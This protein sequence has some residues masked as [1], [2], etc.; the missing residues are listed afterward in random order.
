MTKSPKKSGS[1]MSSGATAALAGYDYQLDVSILAALHLL[2]ISKAATRITLEPTNEEDLEA[3]LDPSTPGRVQ[4]SAATSGGYRLIVQVK[5]KNDGPWTIDTLK[6]L[7][8]K[9]TNRTPARVHLDDDANRFLLITSADVS[10]PAARKLL[11]TG[12]EDWPSKAD[13]PPG[14][15]TTLR[16][17]PEGRLGIWAGLSATLLKHELTDALGAILRVPRARQKEC[18]EQLRRDARQR[19]R[20]QQPGV[21]TR[22]D[23]VGTIRLFGGYLASAPERDTFVKPG[24]YDDIAQVLDRRNAVVITGPSGTGKTWTA[25]A[26]C[27]RARERQGD[28][29]IINVN[30]T[31]EPSSMRALVDTGPMLHYVEDPWGQYSLRGGS[32]AWTTQLPRLLREARPDRQY[33]ITSRSDMIAQALADDEL[34]RWSVSLAADNYQNGELADIYDRRLNATATDLQAAALAFRTRALDKLETPLELDLFF[35]HLADGPEQGE[36]EYAFYDRI[37]ALAHRDAVEDVVVKYLVDSDRGGQAAILWAIL[38]SRGQIDR[39]QLASLQREMRTQGSPLANDLER[40][41]NRLV[42]TRHLRQPGRTIS[43]SHPSVRAGFATFIARDWSRTMEAFD[44]LLAALVNMPEPQRVWGLETATRILPRI[45]ELGGGMEDALAYAVPGEMQ[46]LIDAW[47]DESLVDPAADFRAVLTLACDVGS[48]ASTPSEVARWFLK[49]VRRGWEFFLDNWEPPTFDDDWYGRARADPR[50]R[51]IA[52]R[53]IREQL[54][55]GSAAYGSAFASRLDRIADNLTPAYLAAAL[56]MVSGGPGMNI[57]AVAG[58]AVRDLTGFEAVVDAA[59]AELRAR[60]ADY[61][62]SGRETWRAIVDGEYDQAYEEGY[63]DHHADDGYVA[64]HFLDDYVRE[65]RRLGNWA[66]LAS[67]PRSAELARFWAD[68]IWKSN[69]PPPLNELQSLLAVCRGAGE[70]ARAWTAINDHWDPALAPELQRMLVADPADGAL[71]DALVRCALMASPDTAE[72]AARQ[73]AQDP[74]SII[75]LLV[76]ARADR[77]FKSSDTRP[78]IRRLVPRLA[79]LPA[80][81]RQVLRALARGEGLD[82]RRHLAS[83]DLLETAAMTAAPAVLDA[84]V[85]VL[86]AT[87]RPVSGAVSRWL[88]ETRDSGLAESAAQAAVRLGDGPLVEQ[89]RLHPRASARTVALKHLVS[90]LPDPL[91]GPVLAMATDRSSAVRMTLVKGLAERP[92]PEHIGALLTLLGDTWANNVPHHDEDISYGVAKLAVVALNRYD[93]LP[94]AVGTAL[95]DR[96]VAT[97]DRDLSNAAMTCA[98]ERCSPAIRERMWC[99]VL[100]N[101][102]NWYRLDAAKALVWADQANPVI[103]TSISAEL[104]RRLAPVLAAAAAALLGRHGDVDQA[105]EVF[106][107]VARFQRRRALVVLGAWALADRDHATAGQLMGLLG[108]PHPA[109]RL[110]DLAEGEKLPANALD[111][112]GHIRVRNAVRD[113]L[114]ENIEPR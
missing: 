41:T 17:S 39:A 48:A 20:S 72:A 92:R 56:S 71:Y 104:L 8:Q 29:E 108:D 85:P 90:F 62:K 7:L 60:D 22:E 63:A 24:N 102:K 81:S 88:A 28:V 105:A 2:L 91:P 43:F 50:S 75:R 35:S 26:L 40:V 114:S 4:P 37:I 98:A 5:L 1:G 49:S 93:P 12:L 95:V 83:I 69:G 10:G 61:E 101:S 67:H 31:N 112:L 66:S 45:V 25:L 55:A 59:L 64:E 86:I 15:K 94:D 33:V 36:D 103:T 87:G 38:S 113:W 111:D 14:L 110:I 11:M 109:G 13:F 99:L 9:G 42:A 96:A 68:V 89:A 70:E 6:T 47:L 100:D 107:A 18:L 84:I 46:Q 97:D 21:W 106:T 57:G 74:A 3:D 44:V 19:M 76:T 16:N 51:I 27:D 23:L 73:L 79:A 82:P 52:D 80:G 54:P 58:G 34:K 65:V 78:I 53:F 77:M 30:V 32:E